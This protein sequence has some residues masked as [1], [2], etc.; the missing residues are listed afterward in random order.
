M[1]INNAYK[2]RRLMLISA[3]SLLT[4]LQ[5][6]LL[7]GC[8]GVYGKFVYDETVDDTFE[9]LSV[10]PDHRY[11]FSGGD[12]NPDVIIAIDN[13]YTLASKLWKPIEMTEAQLKRW[14]HNPSRR[15]IIY[16]YTY[17]R[18]ILDDQG[19]RVGVWYALHDYRTFSS[20]R[21][22]DATTVQLSSPLDE[23]YRHHRLLWR[24][25]V[26]DD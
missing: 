17:G 18:Q 20:I 5:V 10:L 16:P 19:N 6:G 7:S 9:Q 8:G 12:S 13:R 4:L 23:S 11:Y 22:L 21:M 14:V 26:W 24:N 25:T 2:T 15:S 3:F 1:N